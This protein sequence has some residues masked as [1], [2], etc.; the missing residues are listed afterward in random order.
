MTIAMPVLEMEMIIKST[1]NL[2][3]CRVIK[4]SSLATRGKDET[5]S[6]DIK[7]SAIAAILA[8]RRQRPDYARD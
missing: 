4:F 1:Q 3:W 2:L 5:R 6:V 8:G 7:F